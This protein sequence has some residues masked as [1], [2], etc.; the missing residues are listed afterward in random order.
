MADLR[1]DLR[2][3]RSWT[4][5]HVVCTAPRSDGRWEVIYDELLPSSNLASAIASL[6]RLSMALV[7]DSE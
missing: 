2:F 5:G 6:V 7:M 3:E 4:H 1:L